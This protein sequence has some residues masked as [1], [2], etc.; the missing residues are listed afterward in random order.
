MAAGPLKVMMAEESVFFVYG[1]PVSFRIF[2]KAVIGFCV[3][4]A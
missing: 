1:Y 4:V 2:S 3:L